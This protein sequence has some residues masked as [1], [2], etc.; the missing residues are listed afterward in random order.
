MAW[1][2]V[3]GERMMVPDVWDRCDGCPHWESD[4]CNGKPDAPDPPILCTEC[5]RP[6]TGCDVMLQLTTCG[7][8]ATAR[9]WQAAGWE[10]PPLS[11]G[12]VL[13]HKW[14]NLPRPPGKE[15]NCGQNCCA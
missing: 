9:L 7:S 11:I 1:V 5:G 13:K 3:E 4:L 8:C 6:L 12:A 15:A 10:H 2:E 14:E